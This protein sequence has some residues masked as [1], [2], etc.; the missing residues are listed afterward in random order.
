MKEKQTPC[1]GCGKPFTPVY[2]GNLKASRFGPCCK[3]K[4]VRK[5]RPDRRRRQGSYGKLPAEWKGRARSNLCEIT[6]T[7]GRCVLDHICPRR[8]IRR[9]QPQGMRFSVDPD[10]CI[11]TI[12]I[13]RSLH[14]QKGPLE[15]ALDRADWCTAVTEFKR[16]GYPRDRVLAAFQLYGLAYA[17]E[18]LWRE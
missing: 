9:L 6:G 17:V 18:R 11:N 5:Q 1:A 13:S 15:A 8:L 3:R 10:D 14:G 4:P 7:R 2:H 12:N 16:L